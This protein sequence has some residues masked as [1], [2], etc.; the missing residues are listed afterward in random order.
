MFPDTR[1]ISL[2][3]RENAKKEMFEHKK[4]LNIQFYHKTPLLFYIMFA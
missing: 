1:N 3:R 2:S 4:A